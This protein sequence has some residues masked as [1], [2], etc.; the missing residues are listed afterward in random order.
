M[1]PSS[2]QVWLCAIRPATLTAALGPVLVGSALAAADGAFAP[3]V[4]AAALGAAVAIQI[5]TNLVNDWA[6]FAKGA[7][8]DERLGPARAV[9]RGWLS[10]R[11]VLAA[12]VL[13]FLVAG[14]FGA[15]LLARAGW[16]LLLLGLSGIASGVLYTAGPAPLGYRGLGDLFVILYFGVAAVSG[17]YYAHTGSLSLAALLSSLAV[18]AL[19]T[20]I[21]VVNNLRD[22]LTDRAAGKRTLVVRFGPRFGRTEYAGLLLGAY[23]LVVAVALVDAGAG[24]GFL[25]PLASL[26]LALRA[27]ARVGALEGAALNPELGSTALLGLAFS[28]LLSLGVLVQGG[29]A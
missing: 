12:A 27:I 5:G 13:S 23:A 2:L 18:G 1:K 28:V 24:W 19:A 4:S 14:L 25:W 16:P 22:R 20:A 11:T 3:A 9:A 6:D 17:T 21:L 26:P 7:D 29:V 10:G 8:N 15:Y